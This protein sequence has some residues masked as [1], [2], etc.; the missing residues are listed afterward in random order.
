MAPLYD[1]TFDVNMTSLELVR[2]HHHMR[3]SLRRFLVLKRKWNTGQTLG[4]IDKR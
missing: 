3:R 1:G 4:A 2:T